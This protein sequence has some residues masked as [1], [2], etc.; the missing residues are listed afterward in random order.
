MTESPGICQNGSPTPHYPIPAQTEWRINLNL[1]NLTKLQAQVHMVKK[2]CS[3][4][5]EDGGS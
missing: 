2:N 4:K 1:E 3:Q 5:E